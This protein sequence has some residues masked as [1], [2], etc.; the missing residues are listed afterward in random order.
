MYINKIISYW[1]K[2][3]TKMSYCVCL[4][5]GELVSILRNHGKPFPCNTVLQIFYQTCKAVQH[6]HKQQPPITHR[7]LKVSRF[8]LIDKY[9]FVLCHCSLCH[10]CLFPILHF[11]GIPNNFLWCGQIFSVI[12]NHIF[13]LYL[14]SQICTVAI[15]LCEVVAKWL[16]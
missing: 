1:S 15:T 3:H 9:L 16:T 10:S 5:G 14:C 7:D 8:L 6:M 11:Q 12:K 4:T 13:N 2:K